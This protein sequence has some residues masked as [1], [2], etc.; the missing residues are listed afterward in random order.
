MNAATFAC[1]RAMM[2]ASFQTYVVP[3]MACPNALRVALSARFRAVDRAGPANPPS[4][5]RVLNN[6]L[7][8]CE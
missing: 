3:P 2:A 7:V 6:S 4:F 8:S 5:I 1:V